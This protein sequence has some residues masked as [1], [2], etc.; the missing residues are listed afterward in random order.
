MNSSW[1]NNLTWSARRA[2]S[3]SLG[4]RSL[5]LQVFECGD[6]FLPSGQLV[7]CD[8]FAAMRQVGNAVVA[9]PPA[10][11]PVSVTVADVSDEQDGS[12]TREAYATLLMSDQPEVTRKLLVP[13]APGEAPPR[14][15]PDQYHGFV[16]DAGTGC[17]VDA[18]SLEVA[19]PPE[20]QWHDS[21]F[22]NPSPLSWFNRMDDPGHI[23][24][25]LAN[26][27]LP[28]A[29]NGENLVLFHSGWGDGVY[30]VIG[31][32][33]VTGALVA[34]HVDLLVVPDGDVEEATPNPSLQRTPPG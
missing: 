15:D 27:P 16:V 9:V 25:G 3:V 5:R 8:P 10:R 29:T 14:L 1:P 13:L 26:I 6:L 24:D 20:D 4:R 18:H 23:R 11:Y 7:V 33:D 21:L 28:L 17:F 31:G 19:M 22:D 2:G 12:H 30:P 32:Y 34:V